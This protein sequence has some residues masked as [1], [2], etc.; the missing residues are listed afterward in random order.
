MFRIIETFV[1]R[2]ILQSKVAGEVDDLRLRLQDILHFVRGDL[3]R[4]TEQHDVHTFCGF[5]RAWLPKVKHDI[6][7]SALVLNG[8]AQGM[9]ERVHNIAAAAA[10][11]LRRIPLKYHRL[12]RKLTNVFAKTMTDDHH[13][14]SDGARAPHGPFIMGEALTRGFPQ[15]H[16]ARVI[17]SECGKEYTV[18]QFVDIFDHD[19]NLALTEEPNWTEQFKDEFYEGWPVFAN[20]M[21]LSDPAPERSCSAQCSNRY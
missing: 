6:E 14:V 18:E 3:V 17:V 7:M 11:E 19:H 5:F 13:E 20:H 2:D 1:G 10:A 8:L 16:S 21:R 4:Q 15:V 9:S 12:R